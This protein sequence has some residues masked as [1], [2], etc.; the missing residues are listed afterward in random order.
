[1]KGIL[2][3]LPTRELPHLQ[4]ECFRPSEDYL[5]LSPNQVPND[6][7][8]RFVDFKHLRQIVDAQERGLELPLPIFASLHLDCQFFQSGNRHYMYNLVSRGAFRVEEPVGLDELLRILNNTSRRGL[9]GLKLE[10]M[11]RLPES[12]GPS[13][14]P[15][16]NV[17]EAW[18]NIVDP[19]VVDQTWCY[20]WHLGL[21][22]S[23]L[24]Y[25]ESYLDGT[26]A[27]SFE[28]EASL[29]SSNYL[30]KSSLN[31][32]YRIDNF[33]GL[34]GIL[35]VLKD[36]SGKLELTLLEPLPGTESRRLTDDEMPTG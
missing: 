35:A 6:W 26:P 30:W 17:P 18:I 29:R 12:S 23:T 25:S 27:Y 31:T 34:S 13:S 21:I 15:D 20:G 11:E 19:K 5:K 7:S 1:M 36:P 32:G 2:V 28:S 22:L 14:V 33:D 9:G 16:N 24:L 3:E 10:N 4:R 8:N